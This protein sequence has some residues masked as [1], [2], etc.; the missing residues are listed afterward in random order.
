MASGQEIESI[1]IENSNSEK[2]NYYN[3]FFYIKFL[4]NAFVENH[5]QRCAKFW[6]K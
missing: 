4:N 2:V 3:S 6:G 1:V 5:K